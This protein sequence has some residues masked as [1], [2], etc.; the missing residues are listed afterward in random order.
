MNGQKQ[1][2]FMYLFE[3][4]GEPLYMSPRGSDNYMYNVPMDDVVSQIFYCDRLQYSIVFSI[5]AN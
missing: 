5:V 4:V 3:R 1:R 2:E